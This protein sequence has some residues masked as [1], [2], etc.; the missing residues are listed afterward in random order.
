MKMNSVTWSIFC[1]IVTLTALFLF[2]EGDLRSVLCVYVIYGISVLPDN[3]TN[4]C[5]K[6]WKRKCGG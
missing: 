2:Q 3:F 4:W 5:I 6:N 1:V